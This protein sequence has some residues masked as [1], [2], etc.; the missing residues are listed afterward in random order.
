MGKNYL[1]E[2]ASEKERRFAHRA[3]VSCLTTAGLTA[4]AAYGVNYYPA[5]TAQ[6][7]TYLSGLSAFAAVF[8]LCNSDGV[9][10]RR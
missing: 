9:F 5:V 1:R 2:P 10:W 6:G 3:L 8:I 7:L 4:G